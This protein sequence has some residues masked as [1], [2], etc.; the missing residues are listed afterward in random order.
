MNEKREFEMKFEKDLDFII[1]YLD[2]CIMM[3]FKT[4]RTLEILLYLCQQVKV[5]KE[6]NKK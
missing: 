5:I 6:R 1:G 2:Q 4:D 3:D